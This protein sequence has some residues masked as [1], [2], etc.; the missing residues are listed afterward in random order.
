LPAE[1]ADGFEDSQDGP[2]TSTSDAGRS[3]KISSAL[4]D[5]EAQDKVANFEI[6]SPPPGDGARRMPDRSTLTA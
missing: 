4:E 6:Q 3:E 2:D 1:P 5:L